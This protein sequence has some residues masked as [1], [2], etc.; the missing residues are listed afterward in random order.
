LEI[1]VISGDEVLLPAAALVLG[2][3]GASRTLTITPAAGRT[4]QTTVTLEVRDVAG[5]ISQRTF[6]VIIRNNV[7]PSG[8]T[9]T[10]G[11]ATENA[12]GQLIGQLTAIDAD[13]GDVHTFVPL[14]ARFIVDA[15]RRLHLAPGVALDYEAGAVVQVPLRITDELG[16]VLDT[17]VT[18]N[19]SNVQELPTAVVLS[20]QGVFRNIAGAWVAG[21]TISDPDAAS[22][23]TI[24]VTD[25]RF[26]VRGGNLYLKPAAVITAAP[27]AL[28][29]IA[30]SIEESGVVG[31][32][33]VSFTLAVDAAP[34]NWTHAHQWR[35]NAFD[36]NADGAVTPL[37][38]LLIII[39][40]N[41]VGPRALPVQAGGTSAPLFLDVSGD[42][43]VG[44]F[45]ALLVVN[46]LN[47]G[48][49]GEG[50]PPTVV[51]DDAALDWAF[52]NDNDNWLLWQAAAWD[53]LASPKRK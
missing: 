20:R 12:A 23:Y 32:F 6:S 21:V 26:E 43:N 36:A 41:A 4:G 31:Q 39:E 28:I 27:S 3:S 29:N 17:T 7:P 10:P 30:I 51:A 48:E 13:A 5:N 19:V 42:G 47:A 52:S 16:A 8:A 22:T 44:P 53:A 50:E 2:G 25:S 33:Q 38:A 14:D 37:D 9:L 35:P 45:D 46:Y 24:A 34:I 1:S 18:V 49:D 40:L 11:T 15:Q